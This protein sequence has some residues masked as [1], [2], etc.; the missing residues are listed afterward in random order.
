MYGYDEL[1]HATVSFVAPTKGDI[2][3]LLELDEQAKIASTG[4]GFATERLEERKTRLEAII[5]GDNPDLQ[6]FVIKSDMELVPVGAVFISLSPH[7]L[8]EAT[9]LEG[10]SY[11]DI[12]IPGQRW[13][14]DG[15]AINEKYRRRG[16]WGKTMEKLE[17]VARSAG[18]RYLSLDVGVD[19]TAMVKACESVG[20]SLYQD[21]FAE[22][23]GY[24]QGTKLFGIKD[25]SRH[26]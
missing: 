8:F 14:I 4:S 21:A 15:I 10:L 18:V 3:L 5:S 1:A 23:F 19:N 17:E 20:F 16:Y 25:L 2:P 12:D 6:C 9:K 22:K 13:N 26:S 7:S 24:S 11:P